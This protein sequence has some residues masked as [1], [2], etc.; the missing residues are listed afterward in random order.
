MRAQKDK[1]KS[2]GSFIL[3]ALVHLDTWL[4]GHYAIMPIIFC[5]Y[6]KRVIILKTMILLYYS[7][8]V[9]CKPER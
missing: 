2:M 9:L 6:F 5:N 8:T 1:S 3:F 7:K 4:G